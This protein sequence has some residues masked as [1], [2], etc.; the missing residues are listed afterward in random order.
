M[1]FTTSV[2]LSLFQHSLIKLNNNIFPV[3][4]ELLCFENCSRFLHRHWRRRLED[5]FSTHMSPR[6]TQY[7]VAGNMTS[8]SYGFR[9]QKCYQ[10]YCYFKY[11]PGTN[12]FQ[13]SEVKYFE[14][15]LNP[16]SHRSQLTLCQ[17]RCQ[18]RRTCQYRL[19]SFRKLC[20]LVCLSKT[21]KQTN[22]FGLICSIFCSL[23]RWIKYLTLW[24]YGCTFIERG[25]RQHSG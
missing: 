12:Y 8:A 23:I 1:Q 21:C 18:D 16:F 9:G 4:K 17:S 22:G 11:Y 7:C 10:A 24:F 19:L 15:F 3:N 5:V 14:D 20:K 6:A 13:F 25:P 2:S